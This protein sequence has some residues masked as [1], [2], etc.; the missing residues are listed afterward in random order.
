MVIDVSHDR[1]FRLL[2]A[3]C[4]AAALYHVFGALGMLRGEATP[5][6]RHTRFVVIDTVAA[7]YLLRRPIVLLPAFTCLVGQQ[8]VS[9]GARALRWWHESARIDALS[10]GTLVT[11]SVALALLVLDARDRSTLVRRIVC[12]FRSNP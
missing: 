3:L 8:C 2:A 5:I 4:A 12:P 10:I 6:G 1:M 11:L 7:W 9:H